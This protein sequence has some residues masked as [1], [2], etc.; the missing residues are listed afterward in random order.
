M[1]PVVLCPACG[2]NNL[3]HDEITVFSRPEDAAAV[4]ETVVSDRGCTVT[5]TDGLGNPSARRGGVTIQ[6]WCEGCAARPFLGF[7]QHKGETYVSWDIPDIPE[8][9]KLRVIKGGAR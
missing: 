5:T 7:A 1:F 4:T 3:H 2:S 6:F 8:A 9:G